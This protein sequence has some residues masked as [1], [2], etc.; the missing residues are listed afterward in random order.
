MVTNVNMPGFLAADH[1]Q[2]RSELRTEQSADGHMGYTCRPVAH[3]DRP[4]NNQTGVQSDL[5]K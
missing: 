5:A 4:E 1:R 2:L 3:V